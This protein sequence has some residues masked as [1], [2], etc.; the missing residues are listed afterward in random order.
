L[1]VIVA[2]RAGVALVDRKGLSLVRS[3]DAAAF[4][5]AAAVAGV[6]ILGIE[7]FSVGPDR[8]A[9]VMD[10]ITDFSA[11]HDAADSIVASRRFL[12]A[13]VTRGLYLEFSLADGR[14]SARDIQ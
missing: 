14:D 4:I 7:G 10:A 3:E 8:V 11:I 9:P 6:W 13:V 12:R 5:D 2:G 1:V